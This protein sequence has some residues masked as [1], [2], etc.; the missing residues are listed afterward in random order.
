MFLSFHGHKYDIYNVYNNIIILSFQ[1][2][3]AIA[4]VTGALGILSV[5]HL[6]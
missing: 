2:L 5:L 4:R 1:Y 6:Y 3:G